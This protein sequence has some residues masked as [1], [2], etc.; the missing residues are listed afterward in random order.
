[1]DTLGKM[2]RAFA[3]GSPPGDDDYNYGPNRMERL[4]GP[5][6]GHF[7]QK[8]TELRRYMQKKLGP[9]TGADAWANTRGVILHKRFQ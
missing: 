5:I 6:E 9:K 3:G 8:K 4:R 1:M 7:A 2:G